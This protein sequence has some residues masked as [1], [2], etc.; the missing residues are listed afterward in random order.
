M[1]LASINGIEQWCTLQWTILSNDQRKTIGADIDGYF[2][3]FF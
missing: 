1:I 3:R 2:L